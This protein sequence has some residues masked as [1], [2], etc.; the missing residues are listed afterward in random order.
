LLR[1][2]DTD[3]RTACPRCVKKLAKAEADGIDLSRPRLTPTEK[4]L[5]QEIRKLRE[6]ALLRRRDG[7]FGLDS[8]G[9]RFGPF[10]WATY[11]SLEAKGYIKTEPGPY[12]SHYV[13]PISE[14][15]AKETG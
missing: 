13:L 7:L 8:W 9:Y 5:W 4:K 6:K 10:R 2:F 15:S 12:G 3:G 11:K 14:E 1:A